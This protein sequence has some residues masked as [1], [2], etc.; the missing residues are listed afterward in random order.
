MF[1]GAPAVNAAAC[2][3]RAVTLT[4]K[5]IDR[6]EVGELLGQGGF[7]AVYRAR[8][9]VVG[10]EVAL[11]VLWPD[12][13]NDPKQVER[14]LREA[15]AAAAIGHP[16]IVRVLD[17]GQ[18]EDG[19]AFLAM[20]RLDGE[21]LEER[22]ERGPLSI[23]EAVTVVGDVL[24]ALGAAHDAGIVHRDLKPG[25]VF[26]TSAGEVKLLDFGISKIGGES[27]LTNTGMVLGTPQFM[28]PEQLGGKAIDG[29][30]DLY[31]AATMLYELLVG[32][33]PFPGKGYDVIVKRVQ[34]AKPPPLL[35]R[36]PSTPPSLAAAIERG[37]A[38]DRDA[39]FANA[40]TFRAAL[41]G[42]LHGAGPEIDVPTVPPRPSPLHGVS[43]IAAA[44]HGATPG[45]PQVGIEATTPSPLHGVPAVS[46]NP[47]MPA[48]TRGPSTPSRSTP[49]PGPTVHETGPTAVRPEAK[50]S[51]GG[52]MLVLAI[53]GL[54][55]L[56]AGG[57]GVFGVLLY[58]LQTQPEPIPTIAEPE[59]TVPTPTPTPVTPDPVEPTPTPE[60]PP[61]TPVVVG[62]GSGGA[63][64]AVRYDI[65]QYTG[66][67]P[68]P[69]FEAVLERARPGVA[70]CGRESGETHV[71]LHVIATLS[72][73]ISI[74]QPHPT[75]ASD[76]PV[77]A[78]CV[79]GAIRSAGPAAFSGPM[80][81]A[82]V[83][84]HVDVPA[85]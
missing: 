35:E 68:R 65:F 3:P 70:R 1:S 51:R 79:A 76:D 48:V 30:A 54:A 39:R 57:I 8:H 32:E 33:V 28:A 80:Q 7:G 82:I 22:V 62:A 23:D 9:A 75:E 49:S 74:A 50:P 13:A 42:A 29:R 5:R 38:F 15:R 37:L 19:T 47:S 24:D 2:H 31:A 81:T 4:G 72:G 12:H 56:L 64:S 25:N 14:F 63:A 43:L 71:A 52:P 53:A 45:Y 27:K 16:N 69:A 66:M 6:Y 73:E 18:T 34:G 11:K 20:E 55:V 61:V 36:A 17:A 46:S 21:T 58:R 41:E 78:R 44:G 40:A 83:D 85:R 84:M 26:L 77:V 59:P 60:P 67:G 10:T